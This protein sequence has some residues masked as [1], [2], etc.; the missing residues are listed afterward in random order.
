[1]KALILDPWEVDRQI[2]ERRKR[3]ADRW[4]EVWNGVLHMPPSPT[5]H[6]Q[7]FEFDLHSWL[8]TQWAKPR[9]CR[10]HHQVNLATPGGWPD[11]NYRIPDLVLLT[12][13][14]FHIDH[15]T[16]MDG[17]PLVVVEIH[18][19]GD[20]A[21]EKLPFYAE[22]GVPEVWIVHRDTKRPELFV[23]R[24]EQYMPLAAAAD[25]WLR[26]EATG[27]ELRAVDG[28]KLAVRL[29]GDDATYA[30]LPRT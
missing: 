18:S 26:S 4:D 22:L 24:G 29:G 19:A 10:I 1:M 20:E 15:N 3:G 14:R 6:H 9:G 8:R 2:A 25:G 13:D 30:E 23:L 21:Y 16:H 27:V 7:E 12:P 17:A 5:V 11:R 28:P